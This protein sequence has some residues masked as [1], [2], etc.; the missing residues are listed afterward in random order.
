MIPVGGVAKAGASGDVDPRQDPRLKPAA[1]EFE[2]CLMKE[3]LAPLQKD[4]LFGEDQ[5]GEDQGSEG[6]AAGSCSALM[7]FG[8]ETLARAISERGGFGIATRILEHFGNGKGFP[9]GNTEAER[10]EE[11][12]SRSGRIGR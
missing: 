4:A 12:S 9:K 6:G 7:G 2:A 1:H 8:A 10:P 11:S 5:G 3:F